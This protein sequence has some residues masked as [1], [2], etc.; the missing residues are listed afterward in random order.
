MVSDL[1]SV[2]GPACKAADPVGVVKRISHLFQSTSPIR[3]SIDC[4]MSAARVN[5]CG[6]ESKRVEEEEA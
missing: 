1:Q 5:G 4:L 6:A 2:C 3:T